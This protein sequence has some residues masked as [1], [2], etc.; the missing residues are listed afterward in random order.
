M[1]TFGTM[2]DRCQDNTLRGGALT[3]GNRDQMKGHI[4]DG[5]KYVYAVTRPTL[6]SSIEVIVP[7]QQDYSIAVDF[8]LPSLTTI[9]DV[10]YT[11]IT[12]S[13][14]WTLEETSPSMIRDL[15]QNF[16]NSTYINLY[17]IDGLDLFMVY[18]MTQNT[19]DTITIS[20]VPRPADLVNET[21]IP[22]GI[23]PE[24]HELI[25]LYAIQS[26]MRQSSPE[27]ALSYTQLFEHKLDE[28]RK[29]KNR[30]ASAQGRRATVG[31]R[32]RPLRP[33]DNSTDW[34]S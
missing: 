9:R 27:Y 31:R 8:G 13:Q 12:G 32:N 30:R 24:F 16:I 28:Y 26:A 34:R 7:N 18:P 1:S 22:V 29:W 17:A 19:G 4:N 21:D 25:E 5:Y 14:P 20:Y 15:R 6:S 3:G 2:L 23:P 33:H 11:S 10:V